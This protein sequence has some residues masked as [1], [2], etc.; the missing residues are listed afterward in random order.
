[1]AETG[2]EEASA[3]AKPAMENPGANSAAEMEAMVAIVATADTVKA[4]VAGATVEAATAV[5]A[6][7]EAVDRV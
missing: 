1:M 2:R 3:A 5:E 4:T 7:V 6:T